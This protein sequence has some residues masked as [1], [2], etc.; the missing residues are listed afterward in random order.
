MEAIEELAKDCH[1]C[2]SKLQI[3][4]QPH[5]IE[6]YCPTCAYYNDYKLNEDVGKPCCSN[7]NRQFTKRLNQ[8]AGHRFV[9]QCQSCGYT[10]N[11][12]I[13]RKKIPLNEPILAFNET[14]H[15]AFEKIINDIW[16]KQNDSMR[17]S[18]V[19]NAKTQ[20]IIWLK[21]HY[22]PYLES[23]TWKK[24]V[25]HVLKR[26]N[27]LCQAC[28]VNNATTAHQVTYRHV[29]TEP[30]F[31]LTSVCTSCKEKLINM[32]I[33]NTIRPRGLIKVANPYEVI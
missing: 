3:I 22:Y 20:F 31:D 17:E 32:E 26:D 13:A 10:D 11:K 14:V 4:E 1:R 24:K 27:N 16:Q 7:K 9:L 12:A 28:L 6:F 29:F 33:D 30:L 2:K 19:E 21:E 15:E 5:C 8:G 25:K 23:E 18:F